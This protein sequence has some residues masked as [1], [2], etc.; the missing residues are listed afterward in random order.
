MKRRRNAN[1]KTIYEYAIFK[2][3]R[4]HSWNKLLKTYSA[5]TDI[6]IFLEEEAQEILQ[7]EAPKEILLSE[8]LASGIQEIEI[9][10]KSISE[11]YR[12]DK[13]LAQ[14]VTDLSRTQIKLWIDCGKILIDNCNV[15]PDTSVRSHQKIQIKI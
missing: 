2:C 14:H 7:F 1:G 15:K 6:N 4:E 11:K 3:E 13:L 9:Y 5:H 10:I 12:L 8:A